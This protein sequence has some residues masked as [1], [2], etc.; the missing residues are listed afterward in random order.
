MK[1]LL[2]LLLIY[3]GI[4]T[5][6]QEPFLKISVSVDACPDCD[7]EIRRESDQGHWEVLQN[8]SPLVCDKNP[9]IVHH[10]YDPSPRGVYLVKIFEKSGTVQMELQVS[11]NPCLNSGLNILNIPFQK[12]MFEP[13]FDQGNTCEFNVSE[14]YEWVPMVLVE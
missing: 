9:D 4:I 1:A 14:N 6:A 5:Y 3:F 2:S 7:V 11:F 10:F 12:G 8:I 13:T